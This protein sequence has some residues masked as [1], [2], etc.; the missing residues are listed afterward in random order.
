MALSPKQRKL[1]ESLR[2]IER[3]EERL[4]RGEFVARLVRETGYKEVSTYLSKY[5]DRVV[6]KGADDTL[7]VR[8]VLAMSEDELGSLLTQ[9]R[10]AQETHVHRYN[11][12][13]EWAD[14]LRSL[15]D[16]GHRHGYV[17]DAE[18][19]ELV[20]GVLPGVGGVRRP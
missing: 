15:L 3:D 8:G 1:Y 5:L 9:K 19:A 6:V 12:C 18:D 2:R 7:S 10:L 14:V 11:N 13:E 4:P 17:L 20:Q 16:Y